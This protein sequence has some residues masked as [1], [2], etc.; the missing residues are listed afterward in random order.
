MAALGAFVTA[1]LEILKCNERIGAS[2]DKLKKLSADAAVA[3]SSK[4][5]SCRLTDI[6]VAK[7]MRQCLR[8]SCRSQTGCMSL[9]H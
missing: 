6:E 9:M 1:R 5:S 4:L 7:L 2:A 8:V 3:I